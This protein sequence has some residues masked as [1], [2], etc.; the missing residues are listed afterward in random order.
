[1]PVYRHFVVKDAV[2]AKDVEAAY[3]EANECTN[4]LLHA[5]IHP[6]IG[7][8]IEK[9]KVEETHDSLYFLRAQLN[10][11]LNTHSSSDFFNADLDTV[12]ESTIEEIVF[13]RQVF[14]KYL[15]EIKKLLRRARVEV[16]VKLLAE[17]YKWSHLFRDMIYNSDYFCMDN[18]KSLIFKL[19]DCMARRGYLF[20][21]VLFSELCPQFVTDECYPV[22][23]VHLNDE[24]LRISKAG[25]SNDTF[26]MQLYEKH[27]HKITMVLLKNEPT[28]CQ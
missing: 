27:K 7:D 16:R 13:I 19:L 8:M 26:Y 3:E 14:V 11:F 10:Y 6:R 4:P 20:A 23:K 15:E 1:M 25:V 17:L 12:P 18:F 28:C 22:F 2:V 24:D 5:D 9:S 21:L